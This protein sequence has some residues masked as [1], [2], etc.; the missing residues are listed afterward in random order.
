MKALKIIGLAVLV[1]IV[2]AAIATGGYLLATWHHNSNN[3]SAN[4]N[5]SSNNNSS[6]NQTPTTPVT[7][8]KPTPLTTCNADELTLAAEPSSDSGA[9]TIALALV[10]TNSGNR[11]CILGGYPGVSLV[12]DNGNMIGKPAERTTNVAEKTVTLKPGAKVIATIYSEQEGNF[13]AGVCADGATKIRV[14][15]PND[16]GY[17]SVAQTT[18]TSWCPGFMTTPVQ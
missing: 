8:V 9:G 15:P 2:A 6:N 1:I 16:T 17:L 7:P 4:N 5:N 14:Y 12:N 18:L 10:L 11:E 3:S 13:D